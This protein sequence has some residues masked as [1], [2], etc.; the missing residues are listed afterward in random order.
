MRT[1]SFFFARD[2]ER[3]TDRTICS[4]FRHLR[5]HD[6]IDGEDRNAAGPSARNSWGF[7]TPC[8]ISM[9]SPSHQSASA[10]SESVRT[11]MCTPAAPPH[12]PHPHPRQSLASTST[13]NTLLFPPT[14]DHHHRYRPG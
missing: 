3:T 9:L 1:F 6:R 8:A 11:D 2:R 7:T 5:A 10:G 14:A 13:S 4:P 12:H